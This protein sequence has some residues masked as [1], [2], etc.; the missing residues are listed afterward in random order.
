MA[1]L[2]TAKAV[3]AERQTAEN[4]ICGLTKGADRIQANLFTLSE[5]CIL[6]PLIAG[7]IIRNAPSRI[8]NPAIRGPKC[9][10]KPV[11]LPRRQEG[12]PVLQDFYSRADT[13]VGPYATNSLFPVD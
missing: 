5:I 13:R 9:R 10:G 2:T 3:G 8:E 12:L 11:C 1:D 4:L 7:F 6:G